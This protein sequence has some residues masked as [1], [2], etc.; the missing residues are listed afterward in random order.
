MGFTQILLRVTYLRPM[1]RP[2]PNILIA[3][4]NWGLGHATRCMPVIDG[5]LERGIAPVLASDGRA[6]DLLRAEYPQ[7]TCLELPAYNVTY[8]SDKMILAMAG[9]LPKIAVAIL[10]E[11]QAIKKIVAVHKIDI[12]ISDNRYGVHHQATR[13]IFMTHQLNIKIPFAPLGFLVNK[14]NHYYI[15]RFHTCWVPDYAQSPRLAGTLSDNPGLPSVQYLG[16]LSRMKKLGV[17]VQSQVIAVLSGPEP[18]R[19]R[20]EEIILKQ[21][22]YSDLKAVLVRGITDNKEVL[23]SDNKNIIIHNYLTATAL[24]QAIAASELVVCRSGY[25]SIMDLIKLDKK[26]I[27]IPTPGQ[28]EQEYLAVNLTKQDHVEGSFGGTF[29]L[30]KQNNFNLQKGITALKR[31]NTYKVKT[32]V[33]SWNWLDDLLETNF[34]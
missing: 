3:P 5:L 34:D 22:E 4:L 16:P 24:N 7:L 21:F 27:L 19:S 6:L 20:L 32:N 30:Q 11:H 14:I 10:K 12:I 8:G 26:A 18:Q 9:Q 29:T 23:K 15:R 17:P 1:I 2:S 25:S 28:T 13:N 33:T 31:M